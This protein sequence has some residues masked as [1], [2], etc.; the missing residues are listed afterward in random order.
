MLAVSIP[1]A[2][3]SF[4]LVESAMKCFATALWSKPG[5]STS[6]ERAVFGGQFLAPLFTLIE[7]G[8]A[9][10]VDHGIGGLEHRSDEGEGQKECG[11]FH[12]R[13]VR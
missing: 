7:F 9:L 8:G 3:T 5:F 13:V 12:G 4:A 6:H 1:N 11:L 2:E 10:P